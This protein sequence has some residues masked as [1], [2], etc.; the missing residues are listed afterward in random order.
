MA[1]ELINKTCYNAPMY[2]WSVDEEAFKKADPE[3]YEIW[4]LE[5]MINYGL[6]GEKLNEAL[7]RKY[8]EKF[9]LDAPTKHYLEFLLWPERAVS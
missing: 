3:G 6:G 9:Y 7:V 8:W 4:R 5:Q 2:N 1:V